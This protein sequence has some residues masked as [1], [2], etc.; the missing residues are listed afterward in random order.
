MNYKEL[1]EFVRELKKLSKKYRTL[2]DD[3]EVFKK[4]V[5]VVD[6]CRNKNFAIITQNSHLTIIKARLACRYLKRNTLRVVCSLCRKEETV[7]FIEIYFK[8][9]KENEDRKR[10]SDYLSRQN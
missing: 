5:V 6:L 8:G 3:I 7:E 2:P 1:P 4:N 9:D 10:I